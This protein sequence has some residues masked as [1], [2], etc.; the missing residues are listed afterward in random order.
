MGKITDVVSYYEENGFVILRG[1][2]TIVVYGSIDATYE[3]YWEPGCMYMPN[4]DPGYPPEEG[5]DDKGDY[6]CIVDNICDDKGNSLDTKL[7][8]EEFKL[9]EEYM[10]AKLD[11]EALDHDFAKA[12]EARADR[13]EAREEERR[14]RE[15]ERRMH[16]EECENDN[17]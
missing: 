4:G 7:T 11:S 1:E 16:K 12:Q 10:I 15:Y 5:I 17:D 3:Y 9:F 13:E 6:D 2:N 8:D 14:L